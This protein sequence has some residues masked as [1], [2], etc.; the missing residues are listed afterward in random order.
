MRK[1]SRNTSF[2]WRCSNGALRRL[3]SDPY[4]RNGYFTFEDVFSLETMQAVPMVLTH[5]QVS[6]AIQ[7]NGSARQFRVS[8]A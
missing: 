5:N 8:P 1:H 2:E 3:A 6:T 4:D 7:A